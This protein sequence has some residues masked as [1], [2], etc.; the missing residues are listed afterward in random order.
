MLPAILL[1][2]I[3]T[4]FQDWK[5]GKIRNKWV[6]S[7][8]I[9]AIIIHTILF[10]Y[11]GLQGQLSSLYIYETLT[12]FFFAIIIGFSFWY[13]KIWSAADG[14]LFI[15]FVALIPISTYNLGYEKWI[16]SITLIINIFFIGL[17]TMLIIIITQTK[18]ETLFNTFKSLIKTTFDI[19][20]LLL[21]TLNLFALQWIVQSILIFI[22]IFNP[23]LGM[24]ITLIA[25]Y[26][27][28]SILK[29]KLIFFSLGIAILKIIIDPSTY[30]L[31]FAIEFVSL[32]IIWKIVKG[33][34]LGTFA[35]TGEDLFTQTIAIKN[36][37]LGMILK[38]YILKKDNLPKKEI[39]GIKADKK[40]QVIIKNNITYIK[41]KKNINEY[42]KYF[43]EEAEGVTLEQIKKIKEIGFKRIKISHTIPF[44]PIIFLGVLCTIITKGNILIVLKHLLF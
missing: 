3:I 29:K 31:N 17:I 11:Y 16:P 26:F 44:A 2:G 19:K 13:F 1:L 40:V 24:G 43:N 14:K 15:A 30:T 27:I 12:D 5:I 18:K 20:S 22:K 34:F 6:L 42:D 21:L 28:E 33:I 35:K 37:K 32:I 8:T 23:I 38:E 4:S 36:I 39:E 10:S 9:Y 41:K 25:Y 7:A